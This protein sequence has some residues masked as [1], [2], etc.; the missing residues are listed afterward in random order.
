M[1]VS[2]IQFFLSYRS[3]RI[4]CVNDETIIV[5]TINSKVKPWSCRTWKIALR[6]DNLSNNGRK[7]LENLYLKTYLDR[8]KPNP[9][10]PGYEDIGK[11]QKELFS[12]RLE[13][14]KSVLPTEWKMEDLKKVLRTLKNNKA[15]DYHGH[16]YELFVV[17]VI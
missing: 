8:L 10:E 1:M 12:L 14:S 16:C 15:R 11:Y 13:E 5:Q 7:S 9:T 3:I 2:Q 17:C 4:H 6:F